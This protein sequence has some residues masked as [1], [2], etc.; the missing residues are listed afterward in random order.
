VGPLTGA[1]HTRCP[2]RTEEDIGASR[3]AVRRL[4]AA[5]SGIR[6]GDVDIVV[7]ELAANIVRHAGGNGYLLC[8]AGPDWVELLAADRGP[9]LPPGTLPLPP[10][11][12]LPL[13]PPLPPPGGAAPPPGTLPLPPP[14]GAAPPPLPPPRPGGLGAGLATV[15]RLA[16]EFGWYAN[17]AGTVILAR[18][19]TPP[20]SRA[21]VARWGAVSVAGGGA[22]VCGDG[23][24]VRADGLV[25][26]VLVDGLG[27]GPPAR[28][29][30]LAALAAAASPAAA[31][32]GPAALVRRAHEAMRGTRGGVL[33]AAVI[34][35]G[36]RELA[37]AAVGNISGRLL[38]GRK[39]RKLV[40]REGTLGT[41]MPMPGPYL[42]SLPW[43]PGAALVLTSDGISSHWDPSCYPGLLDRDPSVTAAVIHRDHERG[44]DDATVVVVRDA[45]HG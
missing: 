28:E 39:D 2:V 43:A 42:T 26:A 17:R 27:H 40:S 30:A 44:S 25:T 45:G 29:A 10:P 13:P 41:E 22:G 4:T 37:Y 11:G 36:R 18:F 12:T 19:G 9:G 8:Q 3:R 5:V 32:A 7:T 35:A 33:A 14:G 31:A 15:R 21:G 24:L 6:L 34:D 16:A 38:L 1:P 20:R 23:W